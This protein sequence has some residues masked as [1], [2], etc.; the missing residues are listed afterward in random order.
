[1]A[2]TYV[3]PR[4]AAWLETRDYGVLKTVAML[5]Y[6]AGTAMC[7]LIYYKKALKKSPG[8]FQVADDR[9]M[10]SWAQFMPE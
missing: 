8:V 3:N 9:Q 5:C 10:V 7:H 6:C 2:N 1:M 4:L